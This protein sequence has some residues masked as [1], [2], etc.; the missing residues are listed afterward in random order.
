[1][2]II[3]LAVAVPPTIAFL[4][5][6]AAERTDAVNTARATTLAQ[7]VMENVLAD[8]NSPASGLGYAA[9]SNTATYLDTPSTGLRSRIAPMTQLYTDMGMSYTV[10][11]TA[12][13]SSTGV[14]TGVPGQDVFRIV[15]VT[16]TFSSAQQSASLTTSM[17]A[18]VTDL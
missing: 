14:T 9:L 16:V 10:T 6:S 13:V 18:M 12:E 8:V 5:Q 4:D 3:V 17:S 7:G 1:M 2:C 15:T 11:A